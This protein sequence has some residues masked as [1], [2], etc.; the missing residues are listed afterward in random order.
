MSEQ[1]DGSRLALMAVNATTPIRPEV[2]LRAETRHAIAVL[3]QL[4]G[5]LTCGLAADGS[6]ETVAA[7]DW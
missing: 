3:S 1:A 6:P 2:R 5:R 4:Y 7:S